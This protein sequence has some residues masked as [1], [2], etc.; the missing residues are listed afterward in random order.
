[1][2]KDLL[3]TN[4]NVA[5]VLY[6]TFIQLRIYTNTNLIL[7]VCNVII[8][9]NIARIVSGGSYIKSQLN[10]YCNGLQWLQNSVLVIIL[11]NTSGYNI[12]QYSVLQKL[13]WQK[14]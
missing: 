5:N 14:Q 4:L 1:M 12:L 6:R 13:L 7:K 8:L 2:H 9:T 10:K 11:N 3:K